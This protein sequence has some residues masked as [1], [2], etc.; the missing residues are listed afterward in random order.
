MSKKLPEYTSLIQATV[1]M[2]VQDGVDTSDL[3]DMLIA[4]A[5]DL[6]RDT[7]Y[8][9]YGATVDDLEGL[10][11]GEP[12]DARVLV[13]NPSDSTSAPMRIV[14]YGRSP[15]GDVVLEVTCLGD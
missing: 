6:P 2:A 3:A 10:L 15:S 8:F 7:I 5:K 12:E 11:V 4:M 13:C 9:E 14:Q 1:G